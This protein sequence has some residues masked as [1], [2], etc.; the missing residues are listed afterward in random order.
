MAHKQPVAEAVFLF[1][2]AGSLSLGWEFWVAADP[3]RW[4]GFEAILLG[5]VAAGVHLVFSTYVDPGA[6][7]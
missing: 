2:L 4:P 3:G 7:R 6:D 5:A 1:I